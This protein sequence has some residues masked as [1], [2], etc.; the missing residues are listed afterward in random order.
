MRGRN[1]T[2]DVVLTAGNIGWGSEGLGHLELIINS[3]N[4][5]IDDDVLSALPEGAEE[6]VRS[7]QLEGRVDAQV[8]IFTRHGLTGPAANDPVEVRT[9]VN[10]LPGLHFCYEPLPYS[11]VFSSGR[12]IHT[13]STGDI[14]FHQLQTDS[15]VGPRLVVEG[16]YGTDHEDPRR[17]VLDLEM[18]EIRAWKGGPGLAIDDKLLDAMPPHLR[19]F[20]EGIGL[21][22]FWSGKFHVKYH[23]I[24]GKTG[25]ERQE[26]VRYFGELTGH[27]LSV[28]FGVTFDEIDARLQFGGS[29]M[30]G[31]PHNFQGTAN[32]NQLR[33]SRFRVHSTEVKF[34]YG[35]VHPAIQDTL[36]GKFT[37]PE[38]GKFQISPLLLGRLGHGNINETLQVYVRQGNMYRGNVEGFLYFDSG[39]QNDFHVDLRADRVDLAK[40]GK[41]IFRDESAE[42]R[43]NGWV[44]FEGFG[45]DPGSIVGE[46]VMKVRKGKLQ[47]LPLFVA[48]LGKLL[49]FDVRVTEGRHIEKITANFKIRDE[50]FHI[51]NYNDLEIVSPALKVLGKG[52]LDFNT[53]L[54]MF[55]SPQLFGIFVP[56]KVIVSPLLTIHVTGPLDN[57]QQRIL[58]LGYVLGGRDE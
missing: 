49:S 26:Q 21:S 31:K 20:F 38:G 48:T 12:A 46:G 45:G 1:G 36:A 10:V 2:S 54:D 11:M 3:G 42:G 17:Q 18:V 4:L 24:P 8:E 57:P 9:T 32:I 28:D 7:F 25:A 15:E 39:K 27:N 19:Q 43:A 41:D 30:P 52:R 14:Q 50:A 40:G 53:T 51:D 16:V 47:E 23:H 13:L 34:C 37:P 6:V 33:F 44:R 55:L 22:G 56:L 58:L 29:A 35:L 5:L